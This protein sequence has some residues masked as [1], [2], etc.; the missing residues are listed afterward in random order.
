MFSIVKLIENPPQKVYKSFNQHARVRDE[1]KKKGF[2]ARMWA[3]LT[4]RK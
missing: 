3:H 2:F 4:Y 1:W